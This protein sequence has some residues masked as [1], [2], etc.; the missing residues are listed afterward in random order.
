MSRWWAGCAIAILQQ[1][2]WFVADRPMGAF[3]V[4]VLAPIL[5]LFPCVCKA[6]EPVGVEAFGLEASVERFDEGV[7]VGLPGREKSSVT[8]RW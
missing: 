2:R 5:Q 4:V 6:Q 7:S 1:Y 3:F 8:P